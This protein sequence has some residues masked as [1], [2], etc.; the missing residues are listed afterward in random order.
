[1]R[2]LG[3]L[4][5]CLLLPLLACQ[6]ADSGADTR[7]ADLDAIRDL[8][9]RHIEAAL[10]EIVDAFL[11]TV[12][13][14]FVLAPPDNPGAAGADD[15]A[16]WFE[17]FFGAYS[18]EDIEFTSIDYEIHGDW[19]AGH[20]RYDWTVVPDAEGDTIADIGQGLYVYR[21]QPDGSWLIAYDFWN[22]DG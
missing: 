22:R 9:D 2:R 1:M 5:V 19:A 10:D 11:T 20:Y 18:I 16:Q 21:R 14:S 13:D 4:A 6:P 15:V 12:T 3:P 17:G 8:H 7:A